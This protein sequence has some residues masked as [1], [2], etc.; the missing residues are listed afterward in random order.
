M[1]VPSFILAGLEA[2]PA[3]DLAAGA[4]L[5]AVGQTGSHS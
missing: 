4:L 2:G 3:V 1:P 5:A